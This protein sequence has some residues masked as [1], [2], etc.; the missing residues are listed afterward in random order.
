LPLCPKSGPPWT[1]TACL[2][3]IALLSFFGVEGQ[4]QTFQPAFNLSN[5]AGGA[6]DHQ[7]ATIGNN[8]YVVWSDS[9]PG[10]FEVFFRRSTDG[11]ATWDATV[12]LSSTQA[13]SRFPHVAVSGNSI[14]IVWDDYSDF[15]AAHKIML[16]RSTDGG[17]TFAASQQLS[18]DSSSVQHCF[19]N[20]AAG[21]NL[22]LPYWQDCRPSNSQGTVFRRSADAGATFGIVQNFSTGNDTKIVVNGSNIYIVGSSLSRDALVFIRSTDS[23]ASFESAK[24]LASPHVGV[25]NF[26]AA[27][28]NL[29][30]IWQSVNLIQN[31]FNVYFTQSHDNGTTFTLPANLSNLSNQGSALNARLKILDQTIYAVWSESDPQTGLPPFPTKTDT[32]FRRSSDGGA[33]FGTKVNLSN[34][35]N[36][37]LPELAAGGDSVYVTWSNT[38]GVSPNVDDI[39]VRASPDR[40]VTFNPAINLSNNGHS[41]QPHLALSNGSAD[42]IWKDFFAGNGDIIFRRSVPAPTLLT[43]ESSE[44]AIAVDSVTLLRDPFPLSTVH[45]FSSDQRTRMMLFATNVGLLQGEG[46]AAV[47]CQAEDSQ[48]RTFV[49]PVEYAGSLPGVPSITQ[50]DVRFPDGLSSGDVMVSITVHGL[51]SNRALITM[52]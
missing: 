24:D 40:G 1:L 41:A 22:A 14:F 35:K 6:E 25:N 19:A 47:T 23:G 46:A 3:A 4:C 48:H 36:S 44:R 31:D 42:L 11:G 43:Y 51:T 27:G 29:Y 13:T 21:A 50:I 7:I 17:S 34:S 2:S 52:K 38:D 45:N 10:N 18:D 12:N 49:M 16:R 5:D 39:I 9:T 15:N 20:I 8:V 33:T 28:T 30:L 37:I 26:V 32:F